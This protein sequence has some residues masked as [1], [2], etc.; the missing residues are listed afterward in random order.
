MVS[1]VGQVTVLTKV[2]DAHL[3]YLSL[4]SEVSLMY[5]YK[6][7]LNLAAQ[8]IRGVSERQ[9]VCKSDDC[10]EILSVTE[11][12][13]GFCGCCMRTMD[14]EQEQERRHPDDP[15]FV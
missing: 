5:N 12:E 10:D 14:F 6:E 7:D 4:K 1:V 11:Q 8:L 2:V 15:C 3:T 13:T 9:Y